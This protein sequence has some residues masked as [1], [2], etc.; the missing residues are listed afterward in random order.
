MRK[1]PHDASVNLR[2]FC[3]IVLQVHKPKNKEQLVS[4]IETFWSSKMDISKC[5]KYI[6]HLHK[7]LPAVVV[8]KGEASGY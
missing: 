8:R 6:S 1:L 2:K 7:V 3:F 4:G 5:E